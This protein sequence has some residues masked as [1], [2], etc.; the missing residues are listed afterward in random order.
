M[1]FWHT[2]G[3]LVLAYPDTALARLNSDVLSAVIRNN[4]PTLFEAEKF[5]SEKFESEKFE[6]E[7]FESQKQQRGPQCVRLQCE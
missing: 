5:E 1:G 3:F 4:T 7:K 6:S 2:P